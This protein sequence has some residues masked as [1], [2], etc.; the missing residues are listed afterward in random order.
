M[1]PIHWVL[2]GGATLGAIALLGGGGGD[3]EKQSSS[4]PGKSRNRRSSPPPSSNNAARSPASGED[5][6]PTTRYFGV[7]DTPKKQ[8]ISQ[9]WTSQRADVAALE[10]EFPG[11]QF[12]E[13]WL[14]KR[15]VPLLIDDGF[16][17]RRSNFQAEGF[18]Y[19]ETPEDS[20]LLG[21]GLGLRL[22]TTN[23][24][25]KG[26]GKPSESGWN[27]YLD[28]G[29]GKLYVYNDFLEEYEELPISNTHMGIY[30][31]PSNGTESSLLNRF[32]AG[33]A[34]G[35][36]DRV[37]VAITTQRDDDGAIKPL[38]S[39][40]TQKGMNM[41]KAYFPTFDD[42]SPESLGFKTA[43]GAS[44]AIGS[45][46]AFIEKHL[47]EDFVSVL[48]AAGVQEDEVKQAEK[49]FKEEGGSYVEA[50]LGEWGVPGYGGNNSEGDS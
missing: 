41:L 36:S 40:P 3:D 30:S 49:K 4:P 2:I 47:G 27:I 26:S 15:K 6:S 12:L 21:Q 23:L 19:F 9:E 29:S 32:P 24:V 46:T 35:D 14:R 1:K 8:R 43:A 33:L 22:S 44:G 34:Y 5:A 45:R 37:L 11:L 42:V 16:E 18:D 48:N 39:G 25:S 7:A 13:L 31:T 28:G 10:K 50:Q 17:G 20:M 38:A